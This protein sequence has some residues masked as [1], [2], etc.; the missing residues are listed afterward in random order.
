M[1]SIF[2]HSSSARITENHSAIKAYIKRPLASTVMASDSLTG[3]HA[4]IACRNLGTR[5]PTEHPPKVA[6]GVLGIDVHLEICEE[7][8]LDWIRRTCAD[9]NWISR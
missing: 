1:I 7:W 3:N 4:K 8:L 5:A 6:M 2:F 9:G